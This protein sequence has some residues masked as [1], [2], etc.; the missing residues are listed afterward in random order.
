MSA[1]LPVESRSWI[2]RK[3]EISNNGKL[4]KDNEDKTEVHQPICTEFYSSFALSCVWN[5]QEMRCAG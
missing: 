4:D 2:L 5:D 1:K 3:K